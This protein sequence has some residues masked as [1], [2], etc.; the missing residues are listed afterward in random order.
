MM[1]IHEQVFNIAEEWIGEDKN[2]AVIFMAI[3]AADK[4]TVLGV[5]RGRR[6]IIV[7]ALA[8]AIKENNHVGRILKE[9][10]LKA[11]TDD[12]FRKIV[13]NANEGERKENE[14]E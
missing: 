11:L 3:E 7:S 9:S 4:E 5:I 8:H 13:D 1:E 12:L 14:H 2:R 6:G 10:N